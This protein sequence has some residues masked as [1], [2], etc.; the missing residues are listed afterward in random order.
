MALT[1][2]K[3]TAKVEP[4]PEPEEP[5][6]GG[7]LSK[8]A[9]KFCKLD[10]FYDFISERRGDKRLIGLTNYSQREDVCRWAI[11]DICGVT[12]RKD[13]DNVASAKA[14]FHREI[15][16]PFIAYLRHKD[17]HAS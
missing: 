2:L 17:E 10:W 11:L 14:A 9:A 1:A 5:G 8:L 13:I 3:P 6:K 15:R 4:E 16:L 12:S 7:E